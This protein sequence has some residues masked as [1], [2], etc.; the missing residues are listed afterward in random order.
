V[1]VFT[2]YDRLLR[3]KKIELKGDQDGPDPDDLIER[4]EEEARKVMDSC[5]RSLDSAMNRLH[6][7]KLRYAKVSGIISHFSVI[8]LDL[9]QSDR[10]TKLSSQLLLKSLVILSRRS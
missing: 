2:K 10:V 4:A 5:V 3:S 1:V 7:Q 9:F 6:T 8:G